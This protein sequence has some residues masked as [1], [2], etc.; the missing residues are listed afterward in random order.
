MKM[1]NAK[2]KIE[3]VAIKAASMAET[4]RTIAAKVRAEIAPTPRGARRRKAVRL[5]SRADNY[6]CKS[7]ALAVSAAF[8]VEIAGKIIRQS[9]ALLKEREEF[10]KANC[11]KL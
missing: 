4:I 1:R 2:R 8:H 5:R 10:A 11:I 9:A 7:A 6:L 3:T